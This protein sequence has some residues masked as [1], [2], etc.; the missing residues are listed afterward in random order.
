M[1]QTVVKLIPEL[2]QAFLLVL[3]NR[4]QACFEV[5]K[6]ADKVGS[7]VF[8]FAFP[9]I[10]LF[11]SAFQLFLQHCDLLLKLLDFGPSDWISCKY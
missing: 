6:G 10:F 9:L 5:F 4:V 1:P 11:L 3:L 7:E 8:S 2:F